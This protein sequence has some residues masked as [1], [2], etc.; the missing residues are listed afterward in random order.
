MATGNHLLDKGYDAAAPISKYRAVKFTASETVGPIAA[1]GDMVCGVSQ[2]EVTAG[3]ITKGKG[4]SVRTEGRTEMEASMAINVGDEVA[5]AADGRAQTAAGAAA[6][7]R[8]I[9]VCDGHPSTLAGHR[10]SVHLNLPGRLK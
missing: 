9:G 8:I 3:E 7:A 1:I 6:G 2:F 5:I 4:A 10:I